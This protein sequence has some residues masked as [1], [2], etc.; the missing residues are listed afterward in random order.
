MEDDVM[1]TAGAVFVETNEVDNRVLAFPRDAQGA[2]GE[3][4]DYTT[5]GSGTAVPHLPSQ[6]SVVLSQD[7][8]FL[9]VANAASNDIS[10][11]A[12]E[13]AQL[14]PIATAASGG[15]SPRSVTELGGT[16]YV[17]NSGKP[18]VAAFRLSDAGLV[19][20]AGADTALSS[21]SADPA[22][23]GLSPDG[24]IIVVTERG[25]DAIE[26]FAVTPDGSLGEPIIVPS[27][28]PTPYGFAFTSDGTLVVTE[29]FRAEKG[30]AAASTY[31]M[32][33]GALT[34]VTRSLPNGMSEICWAVVTNDGRYVFTTN[35]A[36]STVSRFALAGDGSITLEDASAGDIGDRRPGLRDAGLSEDSMYLFAID[37]DGGRV[38]SW[39]IREGGALTPLTPR[40]GLPTTIAGLAAS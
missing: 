15:E 7:R 40:D 33:D 34:P 28:G 24:S 8:R 37:A 31:A 12:V 27:S 1:A 14:R 18:A 6:G 35:F 4:V 26:A 16:V 2:L 3:P 32:K 22:Q 30:A 17:L 13:G 10:V 20:I 5:G 25:T 38:M 21:V 11:F 19:P 36:E 39:S 23:I 9:L 29:A